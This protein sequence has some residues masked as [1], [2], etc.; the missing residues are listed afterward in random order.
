MTNTKPIGRK[1]VAADSLLC[2][3][4]ANDSAG[5]LLHYYRSLS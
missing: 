5:A 3:E 1:V 2:I 4:D